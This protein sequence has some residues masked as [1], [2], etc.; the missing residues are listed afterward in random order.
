[1]NR[2]RLAGL[3][4]VGAVLVG[5]S[6]AMA[7]PPE[8][9]GHRPVRI[10]TNVRTG[11]RIEGSYLAAFAGK[12]ALET[13]EGDISS[14]A[15][16]DLAGDDRAI[17]E[18]R[19]A[20]IRAINESRV[21]AAARFVAVGHPEVDP[22]PVQDGSRK[23]RQAAIFDAFAPF[24]NTRFD[25]RWL[26]VESDGLPHPPLETRM[27]VGITAWQQ[28]VPLPQDY[29]GENAWRIPL[30]PELADVPVLGRTNLMRGAI[31][32]A[33]NGVP[34]FNA[35][36]NRGVDSFLIGELDEFGG[37]CG[38]AD[39]YHY[40]AAPLFI[41]EVVGKGEPIAYALD[42]FPIYGLFDPAAKPGDAFAC[43]RGSHEPLDEL[44][45]HF[46]EVPVGEG[47]GGGTRSYHYHASRSYPYI[48]GGLRG[49]VALS[50]PGPE[51]EVVPQPR[52]NP[53]RPARRAMRGARITGFSQTGVNAWKLEYQVGERSGSV[54]Y[55]VLPDD[56]ADFVFTD[57]D[58]EV[59]KESYVR[60][61]GRGTGGG[62][63]GGGGG[64]SP[65]PE[66]ASG[67]RADE[68]SPL[69]RDAGSSGL[70]LSSEGIGPNGVLDSKYTCDGEAVSPPWS[71]SGAPFGTRS[72]ALTIHHIT[73]E[74]EERVHLVL[75]GIPAESKGLAAGQKTVG[76]LG[77]NDVNGR[78]EYAPP[79]S[80][81]PGEKIYIATLYALSEAPK[82]AG[83]A[84]TRAELLAAMQGITLGVATLELRYARPDGS[85]G[86]GGG[87]VASERR[88]RGVGGAE[89]GGPDAR[90]RGGGRGD[91]G[92]G[93]GGERGLLE[94]MTAF[95]TEV[96]SH[97]MNVVLTRPTET[98]IT[99]SID[100]A[101]AVEAVV[102]YWVEGDA[103]RRR[104]P[105]VAVPADGVASLELTELRP[106]T[107][108]G[109]RVGL[110]RGKAGDEP[111]W[112]E[113]SRFRT[114][115]AAGTPFT[116]VVQADSHLDQG[117]TPEAYE[118]TL[119]N[120]AAA[121]PDFLI[122]LG[123][124]FMTGKR[125]QDYQRARPQYDAQRYYFGLA[126]HAM[127]LFMVLGNHDG[128][129][130]D[131][132]RGIAEWSYNERTSRFPSPVMDGT[133]YTGSTEMNDGRGANY[134]AFGWGDA[135]I[136]VL[137]PFWPTVERSRGGGGGGGGGARGAGSGDG[138]GGESDTGRLSPTDS[139][140]S[141]TLGRAQ[142][143]WLA[144]T[145]ANS[146]ARQKFVFIHHLVGGI[147]GQ[148]ARGGVESAPFFEWG[149]GNA[150]GSEGFAE[151]RTGWP[152][153]IHDLLVKHGVTAVFHGHDHLYVHATLDGIHYQCVPQPGNLGGNTRSAAEYGY[154]S[155]TI[156]GSPGHVRVS[157][158]PDGTAKVEFV[159][160]AVASDDA[161]GRG[162]WRR[163]GRGAATEANGDVI[164][165]YEIVPRAQ[166]AAG[167]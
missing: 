91:G 81:G 14:I 139:S 31:A 45:G 24:V 92:R 90:P 133:M 148:A 146:N 36:N 113:P 32:L 108:H 11:E 27:M 38:R 161:D 39:D 138:A 65:R 60:R 140:W 15:L 89:G 101:E 85:G 117:V 52:A 26:Y 79:C 75:S 80:Q 33:A 54:A 78:A 131:V 134:Y 97:E 4:I 20:E 67:R 147:G 116:F 163:D 121:K 18:A 136:V 128:E 95:R 10:W 58:G 157:V 166:D 23:P 57:V 56:R 152:M 155:G 106:G 162:A 5:G 165:V 86:V 50:G 123:D 1:M 74:D 19:I 22:N 71:W 105:A 127:P 17:A 143:D 109:Y 63:G 42:G 150:D 61:G 132:G 70:S 154:A 156:L 153:P 41:E 118:Q 49:K 99:V 59:T 126:C 76:T 68:R 115:V 129:R 159:R 9:G 21:A 72:L 112:R 44:N 110:V 84:P 48:N 137:D 69:Q 103:E 55:E 88:P 96:P 53:V 114:R 7:H 167:R 16:S 83:S 43:P 149:G 51:N 87:E 100:V 145:L 119:A 93:G 28:Q 62:A 122:D 151:R 164:D 120:M 13:A 135:L 73:P 37:H 35:L 47:F 2:L 40:H 158:A 125:G 8:E 144:E 124:S 82:P 102:E 94:R 66:Q 3:T 130:G 12:I 141:R 77:A 107:E 25:D 160:T 29:S 34:I 98:S 111:A 64:L 46:C 30:E 142:Y 6:I 104:T